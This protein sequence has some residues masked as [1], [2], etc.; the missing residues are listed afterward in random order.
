RAFA[1]LEELHIGFDA[2]LACIQAMMDEMLDQSVGGPLPRHVLGF[3]DIGPRLVALAEFLRGRDVVGVEIAG[4]R[5][6]MPR[7]LVSLC[8]VIFQWHAPSS[9]LPNRFAQK[10]P[11]LSSPRSEIVRRLVLG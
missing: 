5:S 1:G 11:C 8:P 4:V 10:G 2:A 7:P 3:D 6:G 9:C